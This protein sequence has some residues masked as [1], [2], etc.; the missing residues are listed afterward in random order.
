[1]KLSDF[2]RSEQG[3]DT[4][5]KERGSNFSGGQR[6]RLASARAILRDTP[7]YIFDESASNVDVESENDIMNLISTMAKE[8]TVFLISHRLANVVHADQVLVLK[9]GVIVEK[10]T[11]QQ[12]LKENGE[13]A[14]MWKQQQELEKYGKEGREND[15]KELENC[16]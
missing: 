9:D 13:Y 10:G 12:L 7:I 8:K 15:E 1:M 6:Q 11:H 2:L 3:L 14:L 16:L 5:L 4:V